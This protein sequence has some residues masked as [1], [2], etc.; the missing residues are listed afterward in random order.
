MVQERI[1]REI[2]IDAPLEV[3]WAVVTESQHI[4]GWFSDSAQIDLRPGGELILTW[5]SGTAYGRVERVE[6]PHRFSFRWIGDSGTEAR[7]DNS[8]GAI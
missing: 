5:K 7:E 2:S 4:S 3:V 6:P 8:V 1:E